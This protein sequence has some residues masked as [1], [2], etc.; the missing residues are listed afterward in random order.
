MLAPI[1]E[2]RVLPTGGYEC[3]RCHELAELSARYRVTVEREVE[4]AESYG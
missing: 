2:D 3:F 4:M 1:S